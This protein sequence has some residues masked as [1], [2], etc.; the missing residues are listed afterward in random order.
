MRPSKGLL[1]RLK[2]AQHTVKFCAGVTK[3]RYSRFVIV[4]ADLGRFEDFLYHTR[5][6][7][8]SGIKSNS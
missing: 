3:P 7:R 5:M 6:A 1:D 4:T 8:I 2:L